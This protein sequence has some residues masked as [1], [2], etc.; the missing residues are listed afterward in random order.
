MNSHDLEE[1]FAEKLLNGTLEVAGRSVVLLRELTA[2]EAGQPENTVE[3]LPMLTEAT[4][5]EA[6]PQTHAEAAKE[7]AV[8]EPVAAE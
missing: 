8:P 3:E 7:E 2:E 6:P 5:E 4:G 1:P